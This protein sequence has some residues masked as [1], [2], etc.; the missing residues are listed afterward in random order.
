[1]RETQRNSSGK[2][3]KKRKNIQQRFPVYHRINFG[4]GLVQTDLLRLFYYVDEK[5]LSDIIRNHR[6]KLSCA[7]RTNDATEALA[8]KKTQRSDSICRWGYVCFSAVPDSPA[9]CG[10]YADRS[11]GACLIFDFNILPRKH[12]QFF[13]LYG[14]KSRLNQPTWLYEIKYSER[15]AASTVLEL[16]VENMD[17]L[18]TK[19]KDWQH[20][21]EYRMFWNISSIDEKNIVT[22]GDGEVL[23]ALY[24][25]DW[26]L[27]NLSG[28]ILGVNSPLSVQEVETEIRLA[29][30]RDDTVKG[31]EQL[32]NAFSG[33]VHVVRARYNDTKFAFVTDYEKISPRQDAFNYAFLIYLEKAE[34]REEYIGMWSCGADWGAGG[35]LN[36][37]SVYRAQIKV[38]SQ[39]CET[40]RLRTF[41]LGRYEQEALYE[42]NTYVLYEETR[43]GDC[44][45]YQYYSGLRPDYLGKLYA[46]A[47]ES[48][49]KHKKEMIGRSIEPI[50]A[51]DE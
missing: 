8:R 14:G 41:L 28:I 51:T 42:K 36:Q 29:K 40:G 49:E 1:M 7:W 20:E 16:N 22:S 13:L 11:R 30:K 18:L 50:N 15:R 37:S 17:L 9:M 32:K 21:R 35:V 44:R 33:S 39:D 6:I 24:Y 48:D 10:Y 34:W 2:H 38:E 19:S 31:K 47:K 27:S 4:P 45:V 26:I 25:D 3:M 46:L 5:G 43:E 12:G 23:N